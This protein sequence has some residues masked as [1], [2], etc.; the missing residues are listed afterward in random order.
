MPL[1]EHI[2]KRVL[3][4]LT[5]AVIPR[6]TNPVL[7]AD[8]L[9]RAIDRRG[10]VGILALHGL[11]ALVTQHGYEYPQFYRRLYSL[12]SPQVCN[13][14]WLNA[15]VHTHRGSTL[16]SRETLLHYVSVLSHRVRTT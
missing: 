2:Y 4:V 9:T 7:L 13:S 5:S 6:M 1:P 12:L 11:F 10:L 8:F 14:S 15:L 3:Q 16:A